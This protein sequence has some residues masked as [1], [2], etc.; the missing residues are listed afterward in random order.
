MRAGGPPGP[1]PFRQGYSV[2]E[3]KIFKMFWKKGE[4]SIQQT[5]E[6]TESKRPQDKWLEAVLQADR[7]GEETYEM[8]CSTHGL[9]T[10]NP[11]SW[12]PAPKT[13]DCGRVLCM[14]LAAKWEQEL[15]VPA[16]KKW[17]ERQ[18]EEC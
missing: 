11:G 16:K 8:Y 14:T 18:G 13:V 9:P 12:N 6:L 4:D 10:K 3:Q 2:G 7:K 1:N 15:L 17:E 5:F